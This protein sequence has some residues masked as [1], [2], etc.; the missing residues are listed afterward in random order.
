MSKYRVFID[1][2]LP[3]DEQIDQH[4]NFE[5][6]LKQFEAQPVPTT[7][8][9]VKVRDLRWWGAAAAGVV[10]VLGSWWALAPT[11]DSALEMPAQVSKGLPVIECPQL[12]AGSPSVALGSGVSLSFIGSP[13]TEVSY[14]WEK[15]AAAPA[16]F[17]GAKQDLRLYS[18]GPFP[19]KGILLEITAPADQAASVY[20]EGTGKLTPAAPAA[21]SVQA[22]KP[23]P[24]LAQATPPMPVPPK[25]AFAI[26]LSNPEDYPEFKNRDKTFWEYL[27]GKGSADPWKAGLVGENNAWENVRAQKLTNGT[28]RLSFSRNTANNGFLTKEVVARALPDATTLEAANQ[29]VNARNG[30]YLREMTA[31]ETTRKANDSIYNA[32]FANYESK[33]KQWEIAQKQPTVTTWKFVLPAAG[34]YLIGE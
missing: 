21:V 31:W 4:Q 11:D 19:E 3:D 25:V 22:A 12:S 28:Y 5:Q 1:R 16:E 32:Q 14:S 27:P 26:S 7:E 2:K 6:L 33:L 34:R 24:P 23:E 10:I 17:P 15:L 9:P 13:E 8:A 20:L 18:Q 30:A 29:R